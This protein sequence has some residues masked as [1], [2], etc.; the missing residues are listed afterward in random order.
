[1]MLRKKIRQ[2]IRRVLKRRNLKNIYYEELE[3]DSP[4]L[5]DDG[6]L[7]VTGYI[8]TVNHEEERYEIIEGDA[9]EVEIRDFKEEDPNLACFIY[10]LVEIIPKSD[11]VVVKT[12]HIREDDY[13]EYLFIYTDGKWFEVHEHK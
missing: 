13:D 4:L 8:G 10:G 1:M 11:P 5:S 12:W 2:I 9:E 6:N 7:V 3:K